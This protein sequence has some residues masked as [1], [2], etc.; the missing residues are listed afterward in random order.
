MSIWH[1]L[2]E[3]KIKK[4]RCLKIKNY[5]KKRIFKN[6]SEIG[7]FLNKNNKKNSDLIKTFQRLFRPSLINGE[8]DLECFLIAKNLIKTSVN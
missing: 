8:I 5:E 4:K 2:D 6:L 7:Y 1:K 3:N